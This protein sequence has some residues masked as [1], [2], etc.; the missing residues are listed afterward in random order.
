M[1]P[2][3]SLF[4]ED[5]SRQMATSRDGEDREVPVVYHK[6]LRIEDHE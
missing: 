1:N 3:L 5:P 2:T 4:R 6:I